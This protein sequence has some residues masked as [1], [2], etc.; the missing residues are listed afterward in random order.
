[1]LEAIGDARR[2]LP[3]NVPPLLA[4]EAMLVTAAL[5]RAA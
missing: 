3:A 5:A 4:I 1:V 2:R